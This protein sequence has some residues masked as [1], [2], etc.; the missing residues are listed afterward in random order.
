MPPTMERNVFIRH[1]PLSFVA[2]SICM[3]PFIFIGTYSKYLQ[4]HSH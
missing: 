4:L 3:N 1:P 2:D